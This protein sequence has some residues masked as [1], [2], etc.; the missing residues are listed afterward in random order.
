MAWL[1]LILV[2]ILCQ[3]AF[4]V[5]RVSIVHI[6]A[7]QRLTGAAILSTFT[8]DIP[9]SSFG[10]LQKIEHVVLNDK[11]SVF[12]VVFYHYMYFTCILMYI[13]YH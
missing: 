10:Q 1:Y 9:E 13:V 7:V 2:C 6:S 8:M 11:R 5:D 3:G 4:V 12:E